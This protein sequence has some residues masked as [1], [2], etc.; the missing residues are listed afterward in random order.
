MIKPIFVATVRYRQFYRRPKLTERMRKKKCYSAVRKL[1][2]K[3]PRGE[4][5]VS[6]G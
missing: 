2:K 5:K 1:S 4:A 3:S 6:K